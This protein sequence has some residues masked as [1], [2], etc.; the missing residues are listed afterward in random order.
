MILDKFQAYLPILLRGAVTTVWLTIAGIILAGILAF[1]AGLANTSTIRPLRAVSRIYIEFFRGTSELVQLYWFAFAVPLIF[2]FRLVPLAVAVLVLGLNLGS[3]GAEVVRGA[4][5]AV[6]KEQYEGAVALSFTGPQRMR[7][8]ILPQAL[9]GMLPPFNNLAIQ[10]LKSTSVVSLI[11]V[12]EMMGEADQLRG[13][14]GDTIPIFSMILVIYFILAYIITVLMRL[15]ERR[16]AASI[17][18]TPAKR[19][20]LVQEGAA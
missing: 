16:A 9:V 8:V 7:R 11:G 5:L 17:G 4:I 13:S 18:S 20:G 15:L 10:L 14:T 19:I 1:A 3:Y 2:G 6:P 12:T